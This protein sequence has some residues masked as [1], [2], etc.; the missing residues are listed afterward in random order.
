MRG[1]GWP[2]RDIAF[3]S[4]DEG[5]A[6]HAVLAFDDPISARVVGGNVDVLDAISVGKGVER[7]NECC[8]IVCNNLFNGSPSAQDVLEDERSE[9]SAGFDS[10]RTP[11]GPR[12][13]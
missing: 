1:E 3:T 8:A 13:Q 7:G 10:E 4:F 9:G 11:F 12:S 2:L 6:D 5:L